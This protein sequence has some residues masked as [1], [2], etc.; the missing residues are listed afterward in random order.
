MEISTEHYENYKHLDGI[1]PGKK[2]CN[3]CYYKKL[4]RWLKDN[5]APVLDSESDTTYY[6]PPM[7]S[8]P[9]SESENTKKI[10]AELAVDEAKET[11]ISICETLKSDK[12]IESRNMSKVL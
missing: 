9:S 12:T 5:P 7:E 8:Q 3:D 6:S 2:L 4:P 10:A 1:V 11:I